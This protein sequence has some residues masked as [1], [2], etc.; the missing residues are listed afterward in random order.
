MAL[1]TLIRQGLSKWGVLSIEMQ[2]AYTNDQAVIKD[3]VIDYVDSADITGYQEP[4][5]L[6]VHEEEPEQPKTTA[7]TLVESVEQ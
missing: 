2:N 5:A 3:G 4:P 6:P 1:K 7:K